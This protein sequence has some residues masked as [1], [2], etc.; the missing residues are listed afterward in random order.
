MN[1]RVFMRAASLMAGT[2]VLDQ[3]LSFAAGITGAHRTK[4]SGHIWVYA[5][6]YPP[7]WDC[8]P[9]I[10]QAFADFRF[11]GLDG[12]ELMAVN[13]RHPDAVASLSSLSDQYQ[14]P[15]T[16]FSYEAALWDA[17][18][19]SEIEDD[20]TLLIEKLRTLKGSTLGMS[21]GDA[22]HIK[23]EAELD[24][25]ASLLLRLQAVCDKN[26]VV[27]NLH[28][29][30]YEVA[31]N[32]HDLK[33]TLARIP[34]IKLGPDLNWLVRAG[35]DPVWFINTYGKQIVYM[36][37]RDQTAGG[38]WTET[39]GSGAPDFNAIAQA[40]QSV[41]FKGRAAIELAFDAPPENP[42]KEDWKLSLDY[43]KKTFAW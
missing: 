41:N 33:G 9:I 17:A 22:G 2:I 12:M 7:H 3:R 18:K 37:I 21:V 11:A 23:S 32:L 5:S 16:G 38:K 43:V 20:A 42:L 15:V 4:V 25:Q 30:T 10:E 31:G 1:R 36:H 34:E 27:L 29:H 40:L 6:K 39:V 13:L 8:T 24:N 28:N 35:V 26:Q 19:H 14:V